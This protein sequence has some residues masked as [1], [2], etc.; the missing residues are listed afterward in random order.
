VESAGGRGA[1][2]IGVLESVGPTPQC[3]A[4]FRVSGGAGAVGVLDVDIEATVLLRLGALPP[5]AVASLRFRP[6]F[7]DALAWEDQ[8]GWLLVEGT[9]SV[10]KRVSCSHG[11]NKVLNVGVTV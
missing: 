7:A 5:W 1:R 10:V 11:G 2:A 9:F 4:A 3:D 8:E 6:R